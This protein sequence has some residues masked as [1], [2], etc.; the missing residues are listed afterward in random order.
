MFLEEYTVES[1]LEFS[2]RVLTFPR[3]RDGFPFPRS[4][5]FFYEMLDQIIIDIGVDLGSIASDLGF[6]CEG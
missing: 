4:G 2:L 6:P 1:F 5:V 3:N